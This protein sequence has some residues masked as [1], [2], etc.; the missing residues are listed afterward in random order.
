MEETNNKLT[1]EQL[2]EAAKQLQNRVAM[3]EAR[4]ATINMAQMRLE[5]LL[6][7]LDRKDCFREVF[8][9]KCAKEIE[10]ILTLEP[11]STEKE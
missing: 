1:Y 8:V 6:K 2:E 9:E 11:Q 10:D 4:L 5:Y 3:A 7:V